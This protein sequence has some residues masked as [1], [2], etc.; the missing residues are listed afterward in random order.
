M[1]E[2]IVEKNLEYFIREF[3]E[4]LEEINPENLEEINPYKNEKGHFTS[5]K[6]AKI[7]SLT[8]N[9]E[10]HLA[11]DSD[12]EIARGKV[13]KNGKISSKF[14]MNTGSPDKQCGRLN[15]D[16]SKKKKTRSCKDYP[17]PYDEGLLVVPD[18]TLKVEAPHSALQGVKH[19][20]KAIRVKISKRKSRLDDDQDREVSKKRKRDEIFHGY[21]DLQSLGRG[22]TEQRDLEISLAELIAG[23]QAAYKKGS[24]ATKREIETKMA[25]AGFYSGSKIDDKCRAMSRFSLQDWMKITNSQA[26]ASKGELFKKEKSK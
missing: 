20:R 19:P 21:G 26:L 14:G 1:N 15:I 8:K 23:L 24:P 5:K 25:K 11:K 17:K 2:R 7:Y 18:G 12:V 13:T 22:I 6:K 3:R 16:G 10:K 4:Y 9:A